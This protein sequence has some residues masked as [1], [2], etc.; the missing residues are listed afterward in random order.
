MSVSG[1]GF[2]PVDVPTYLPLP[3]TIATCADLVEAL[4]EVVDDAVRRDVEPASQTAAAW[5]HPPVILRCGVAEPTDVDPTQAVLEVAGV[6]WRAASGSG[7][8]FFYTDDRAVVVEVAVPDDYAPE[9][10][11]LSDL[12]DAVAATVPVVG[13]DASEDPGG[14]AAQ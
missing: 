12:A 9:A 4:P 6:G 11:V 8:T 1:C 7:G 14:D 13:R 10:D 2:G 3:G 5:G